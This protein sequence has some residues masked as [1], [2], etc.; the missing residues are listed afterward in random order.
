MRNF[1]KI[2]NQQARIP[3]EGEYFTTLH[4]NYY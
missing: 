4:E 2:R 1:V 3:V